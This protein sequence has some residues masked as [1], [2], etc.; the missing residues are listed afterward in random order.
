[1]SSDGEARPLI[2]LGCGYTGRRVW[3]LAADGGLAA[4]ATSRRPDERLSEVPQAR[5]LI[6]DLV[7]PE[8]WQTLPDGADLLWCFPAAPFESIR[9]WAET[10]RSR[11][12]RLI[13][14]G[15]TSAY[16][17][18]HDPVGTFPPPWID[19]SAPIDFSK[20]RVLSEE[21]LRTEH[22][23][24]VLRVA[25]I[26][27]EGRNPVEWIRR[28]LVRPSDKYVNLIHVEDLANICLLARGRARPGETY[29]V[30]DG[31]PRT[32]KEIYENAARPRGIVAQQTEAGTHAG[33]RLSTAKLREAF[34]PVIE[35][36]D[37]YA[38]LRRLGKVEPYF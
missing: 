14:L 22:G 8:T 19:E 34:G 36:A 28:G 13:V 3:R 7:S 2:V 29:N 1:M 5:R 10:R 27:G 6:F 12:H 23:A 26:Y 18:P 15:S 30:S 35:H 9:L 32:W 24:T 33:K 4:W 37:L 31:T 20:P 25:G 38:E 11:L 16:D 21:Y 17:V